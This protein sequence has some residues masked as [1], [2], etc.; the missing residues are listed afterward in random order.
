[1]NLRYCRV[2]SGNVEKSAAD[3]ASK[4]MIAL[5][6]LTPAGRIFSLYKKTFG[7]IGEFLGL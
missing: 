3:A 2:F 1:M 6:G 5:L 7:V 4:G